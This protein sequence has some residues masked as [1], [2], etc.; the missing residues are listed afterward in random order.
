MSEWG[1][2]EEGKSDRQKCIPVSVFSAI[3]EN[4]L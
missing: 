4:E 2:E 1:S 3:D